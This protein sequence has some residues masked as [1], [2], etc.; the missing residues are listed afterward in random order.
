MRYFRVR[1]WEK[2]QHY[3]G[4]SPAW[5][6]L[7]AGILTDYEFGC[8]QDASKLHLMLIWVLASKTG[9]RVPAD[10]GWL[11]RTLGL[12]GPVELGPLIDGGFLEME[13][14][15]G[16]GDRTGGG[17][18]C[19]QDDSKVQ[20]PCL[21]SACLE[22]SREEK[23][24]EEES[25]VSSSAPI[26]A[27]DSPSGEKEKTSP[28]GQSVPYEKLKGEWNTLAIETGLT[29]VKTLTDGRKNK[30]RLR[31]AEWGRM[32]GGAEATWGNILGAIQESA[33]LKG[34]GPPKDGHVWRVTFHWL[35][36]GPDNSVK[37]LEGHYRDGKEGAAGQGGYA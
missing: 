2:F 7:H 32:N 11:G 27:S 23:R 18:E 28:P 8:L 12:R 13:D 35:F 25:R 31:W 33:F 24:R 1:N 36:D 6:K 22:E 21:Q 16:Q 20:A 30:V 37:V 4:R 34:D 26:G 19:L 5:I 14:G 29:L 10:E 17:G 9:N 15:V 3:K